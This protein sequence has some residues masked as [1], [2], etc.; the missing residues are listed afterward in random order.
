MNGKGYVG[1][2]DDFSSGTNYGD[3]WCFDPVANSWTQ[4]ADFGGAA[5]RYLSCMVIG[6]RAFAGLGTSGINYCDFWEYGY[7]SDV[8]EY[9]E[10]GITIGPNPFSGF[11]TVHFNNE[12]KNASYTICDLQGKVVREVPDVNGKEIEIQQE[13]LTPGIYLLRVDDGEAKPLISK[14][15]IQ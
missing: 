5:R 9:S 4:V 3:F 7:I 10:D 12:L 15:I 8:N 11:T 13:Q 6:N 14:L 1:C 2:G